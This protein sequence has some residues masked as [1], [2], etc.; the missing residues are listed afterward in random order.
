MSADNPAKPVGESASPRDRRELLQ[1]LLRLLNVI[2]RESQLDQV[3]VEADH[4]C[5]VQVEVGISELGGDVGQLAGLVLQED[6]DQLALLE[7]DVAL[8]ERGSRLLNVVGDD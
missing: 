8:L 6:R 5:G 4:I 7:A 3:A 1:H 2:D